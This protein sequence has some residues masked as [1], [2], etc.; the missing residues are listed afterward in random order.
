MTCDDA[1]GLD[2]VPAPNAQPSPHD[3]V[4]VGNS[5]GNDS[6]RPQP[7]YPR[8]GLVRSGLERISRICCMN[9]ATNRTRVRTGYVI[10]HPTRDPC[11]PP[12]PHSSRPP[13]RGANGRRL[14]SVPCGAQG[15]LL[16][17]SAGPGVVPGARCAA[18]EQF[19]TRAASR[20]SKAAGCGHFPLLMIRPRR[21]SYCRL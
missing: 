2:A 20:V 9:T 21:I 4:V 18:R 17:I 6:F 16:H 10:C 13:K 5:R 15:R 14:P 8:G 19:I 11:N 3:G 7:V 1:S 12:C